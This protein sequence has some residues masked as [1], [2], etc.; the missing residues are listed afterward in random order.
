MRQGLAVV[1]FAALGLMEAA[2]PAL[3][4]SAPESASPA[5]A[6][7]PARRIDPIKSK[8]EIPLYPVDSDADLSKCWPVVQLLGYKSNIYNVYRELL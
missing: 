3:A 7:P 1:I 6:F 4:Q 5:A 2:A 8:D